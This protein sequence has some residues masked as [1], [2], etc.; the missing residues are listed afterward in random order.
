VRYT[1]DGPSVEQ[2]VAW[3]EQRARNQGVV[4]AQMRR[5]AEAYGGKIVIPLPELDEGMEEPAVANNIM[6][7]I[8]QYAGRIASTTPNLFY[9]P[10]RPGIQVSEDKARTRTLANLGWWE[11]NR[12]DLKLRR[13]A[14]LLVGLGATPVIVTPDDKKEC[15]RWEYRDPMNTFPNDT[16][17]PDEITPPDVIYKYPRPWSWLTSNYR[18]EVI[19][20]NV[21]VGTPSPNDRFD[22]IEYVDGECRVLAVLGSNTRDSAWTSGAAF[23]E[24]LRVPNRAGIC[25]GVTPGRITLGERMGQF[26]GVIGM[27]K[28]QAKLMALELIAAERAV[29]PAM[30]IESAPGETGQFTSGP[31]DGRSGF[32]NIIKGGT[33][34]EML[35]PSNVMTGQISDRLERNA[36]V[37]S[38]VAAEMGGESQSNVRTGKRGDSIMSAVIDQPVAEAQQVLAASLEAENKIAVAIAK[39]Y[40]GNTKKSFYVSKAK[41]DAVYVAN[42]AFEN[43]RNVVNYPMMGTDSNAQTIMIGQLRG[44]GMLS[45][46]TAMEISPLIDDPIL[47]KRRVDAEAFREAAKA[48]ILS[49]AQAGTIPPHDISAMVR[50]ILGGSEPED[51][52]DKVHQQ[53]QQRQ[54]TLA[55]E[56]AEG[57]ATAPEAQPGIANPGAGAEQP[58]VAPPTASTQNLSDLLNTMRRPQRMS[59]AERGA[60]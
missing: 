14:R 34:K 3:A 10:V 47:E 4:I 40:W 41:T 19:G 18:N 33:Y 6:Q 17:D 31:Y 46:H 29:F 51:A 9:P 43:D 12:M 44:L 58:T 60:A 27:Y 8:D 59:P 55:P 37:T 56:A 21:G 23:A 2:I 20:L 26:D 24:L 25:L 57:E 42:D 11:T 22:I 38:G 36:R 15:P 52:I 53:A 13:R 48:A 7:G 54:A 1:S 16:G 49:Q 5:V 39:A 32:V 45:A 35:P 28:T 50:L 30:Y